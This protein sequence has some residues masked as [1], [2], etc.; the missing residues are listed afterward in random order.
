MIYALIAPTTAEATS[1]SFSAIAKN[2][3]SICCNALTGT[4]TIT[5]QIYDSA[6][7][8][9]KNALYNNKPYQIDEANNFMT[10]AL[11]TQIYRI[12]KSVTANPIGVNLN[13]DN[14]INGLK[15]V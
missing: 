2:D 15:K 6:N 7:N 1:L 13:S 10:I 11:D 8:I 5:L 3:V 14:E 12:V 4:E 9:W